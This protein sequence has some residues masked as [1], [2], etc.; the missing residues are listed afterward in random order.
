MRT[1]R[2]YSPHGFSMLQT[3][4]VRKTF[5]CLQHRGAVEEG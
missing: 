4:S 1:L 5:C 2:S 3:A